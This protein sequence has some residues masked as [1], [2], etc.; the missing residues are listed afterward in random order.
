M[1]RTAAYKLARLL[2]AQGYAVLVT[3][4]TLAKGRVF[5]TV[6]SSVPDQSEG[7]QGTRPPLPQHTELFSP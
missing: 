2:R 1:T 7:R 3:R 6:A 4:H 5:Y